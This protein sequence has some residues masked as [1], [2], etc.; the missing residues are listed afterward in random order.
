MPAANKRHASTSLPRVASAEWSK[1][2]VVTWATHLN[3]LRLQTEELRAGQLLAELKLLCLFY[4]A[5]HIFL[6]MYYEERGRN[7]PDISY[8]GG[9]KVC[10]S[11]FPRFSS[12]SKIP[13]SQDAG[14]T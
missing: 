12:Q 4:G 8:G 11:R 6:P 7:I 9:L 1:G 14:G 10:L 13:E 2:R 5:S 3:D